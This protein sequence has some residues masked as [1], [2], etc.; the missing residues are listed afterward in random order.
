MLRIN[1]DHSFTLMKPSP[2][3]EYDIK[4]SPIPRIRPP[5]HKKTLD[6]EIWKSINKNAID[7]IL[8]HLYNFVHTMDTKEYY[9]TINPELFEKLII[10]KIYERS[11]NRYVRFIGELS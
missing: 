11:E 1:K 2:T 6:F 9:V 3:S 4:R 7:M 5:D 10:E 8:Y